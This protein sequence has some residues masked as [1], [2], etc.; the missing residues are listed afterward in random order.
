QKNRHSRTKQSG[1]SPET[2]APLWRP[3]QSPD[4][5]DQHAVR[6]PGKLDGKPNVFARANK[7]HAFSP[8][9]RRIVQVQNRN[10]SDVLMPISGY[11]DSSAFGPLKRIQ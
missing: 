7:S 9:F 3:N 11:G 5:F 2:A 4:Q 6:Q 8:P 1:V 10:F